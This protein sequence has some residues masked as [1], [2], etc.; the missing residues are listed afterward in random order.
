MDKAGRADFCEHSGDVGKIGEGI[1]DSCFAIAEPSADADAGEAA[2]VVDAA[3]FEH[4]ASALIVDIKSGG[5]EEIVL[6][7]FLMSIGFS[8]GGNRGRQIAAAQGPHGVSHA[9]D[10]CASHWTTIGLTTGHTGDYTGGGRSIETGSVYQE[11]KMGRA[12]R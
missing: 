12:S 5:G 3:D 7:G 1:V 6:D 4:N 8:G 11:N 9:R 2:I 10:A